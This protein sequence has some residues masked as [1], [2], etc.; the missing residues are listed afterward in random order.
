MFL[1]VSPNPAIDKRLTLPSLAPGEIHRA[2]TVQSFPG[3]KSTHVAMVLRTLGETPHWIGLCGG[4]AGEQ[5]VSGLRALGIEP[6]PC[7]TRKETRTNLEIIDGA[8]GVTEIR[9]PGGTPSGE[10]L[11]AFERTCK[12]LFEQGGESASIIFSGSLPDGVAPDLYAR[13]IAFAHAAGCRTFLDTS[14]EP[15]RLALAAQPSFV[16]PNREEAAALLGTPIN[17]PD[18][19]GQAIARLLS[20]GAHSAALSIGPDGLLFCEAKNAPVLF[21]PALPLR[22]RSTVGCGDAALAGFA[23]TIA[24]NSSAEDTIRLAAA[25][26]AANCLAES[27]G[28]ASSDDIQEFRKQIQVESQGITRIGKY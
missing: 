1:C 25:C 18:S 12:D 20:L 26:A 27:P 24:S 8:G 9:E 11:A 3:G 17:S 4:A 16:K 14:G 23:Y 10:E 7:A 2:R 28:A 5:L 22:P 21:G 15:L 6:H 13:L 19:A